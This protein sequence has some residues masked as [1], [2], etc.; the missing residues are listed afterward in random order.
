MNSDQTKKASE[1]I[2]GIHVHIIQG[3]IYTKFQDPASWMIFTNGKKF[4]PKKCEQRYFNGYYF[5]N[6]QTFK[7]H[8]VCSVSSFF[9]VAPK[10]ASRKVCPADHVQQ[11][12]QLSSR[13]AS[14]QS[15]KRPCQYT[16]DIA[17]ELEELEPPIQ[18]NTSLR[19]REKLLIS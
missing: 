18:S 12:S 7:I 10:P 15:H 5:C 9:F 8:G 11:V 6:L 17:I 16:I 1:M 3:S 19:I 4:S 13:L 2:F 14:L